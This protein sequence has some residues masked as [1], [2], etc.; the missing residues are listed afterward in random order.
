M[1]VFNALLPS[2][3]QELIHSD[4]AR[5]L[6]EIFNKL[7]VILRSDKVLLESLNIDFY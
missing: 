2:P 1:N 5:N 4:D 6:S 7:D 3:V